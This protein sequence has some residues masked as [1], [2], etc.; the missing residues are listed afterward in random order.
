MQII[1][2]LFSWHVYAIIILILLYS[3]TTTKK[4]ENIKKLW[5]RDNRKH[6]GIIITFFAEIMV[7]WVR[8]ISWHFRYV[9]P[10]VF[11]NERVFAAKKL[12]QHNLNKTDQRQA[13]DHQS[14][15]NG[16]SL[17]YSLSCRTPLIFPREK[18]WWDHSNSTLWIILSGVRLD[19]R[20]A[21]KEV[22]S[23]QGQRGS[24]PSCGYGTWL[25]QPPCLPTG[26]KVKLFFWI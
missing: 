12:R 3:K 8:K 2:S 16:V 20:T 7:P 23:H 19:T 10:I 24:G 6:Q 17:Y 4:H 9:P 11:R 15:W 5:T 26:S 18:V 14:W 21:K 13:G 25:E 1:K 22:M